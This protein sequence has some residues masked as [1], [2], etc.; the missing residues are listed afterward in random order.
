ML[1]T[2]LQIRNR[3]FL[4]IVRGAAGSVTREGGPD[5]ADGVRTGTGGSTSDVRSASPDTIASTP[6]STASA[7]R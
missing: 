3:P 1:L 2:W 6:A 4:E 7:T 5:T